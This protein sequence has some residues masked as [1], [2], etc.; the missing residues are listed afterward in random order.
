MKKPAGSLRA[1]V[2][3][4]R[5]GTRTYAARHTTRRETVEGSGRATHNASQRNQRGADEHHRRLV[6]KSGNG[7][8]HL[9]HRNCGLIRSRVHR[10]IRGRSGRGHRPRDE[11]ASNENS[12]THE[13]THDENPR[14][15]RP[16][17]LQ[18]V[19]IVGSSSAVPRTGPRFSQ[20]FRT[21]PR[22]R[23]ARRKENGKTF[24]N[25]GQSV[26]RCASCSSC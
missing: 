16:L 7:K 11:R 2:D 9:L 20:Y 25:I 4:G 15:P 22:G 13:P 8:L 26:G 24:H 23:A 10:V 5:C 6:A 21:N 12:G 14:E 18:R 19:D 3:D 17:H 1:R